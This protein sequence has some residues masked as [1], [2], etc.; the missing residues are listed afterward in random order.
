[1]RVIVAGDG[2]WSD[3]EAIRRELAKLPPGSTIIHGDSPGA[4][5]IAGRVATEL[6]LVVE[7]WCKEKADYQRYQ[8]GA[9]RGLNER[10]LA[11]GAVLVLAFHSAIEASRGTKHLI[12]LA[13]AAGIE[14]RLFVE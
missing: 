3:A 4:D 13:E 5:A 12:E 11:S 8:R 14:V 6:G 10:M 9:W 2:A 7:A 1:M